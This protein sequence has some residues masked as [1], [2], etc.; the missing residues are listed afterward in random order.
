[1]PTYP[2]SGFVAAG[3]IAVLLEHVTEYEITGAGREMALTLLRAIGHLS[4]DR[5]AYRD[6]P[7]GP[8]LATPARSAAVSG[9]SGWR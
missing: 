8:Q 2:A 3:G 9:R 7:A 4:R 1:M 6:Q 5:N